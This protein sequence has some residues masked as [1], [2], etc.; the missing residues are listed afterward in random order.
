MIDVDVWPGPEPATITAH[1]L[2]GKAQLIDARIHHGEDAT[3]GI[4]CSTCGVNKATIIIDY[5]WSGTDGHIFITNELRSNDQIK[6]VV[7]LFVL[8]FDNN[9]RQFLYDKQYLKALLKW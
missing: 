9:Q 3:L 5:S 7:T 6:K 4:H 8:C 2:G 1:V